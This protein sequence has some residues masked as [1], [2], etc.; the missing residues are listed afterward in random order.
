MKTIFLQTALLV[1]LWLAVAPS[2]ALAQPVP[3]KK[4]QLEALSGAYADPKPYRYGQAWGKRTFTFQKGK[5]TLVF[6][7]ALDS[8]LTMPVFQF[9]TL[10]TYRLDAPSVSVNHAWNAVFYET[11]KYLTLKTADPGL[12]QAFGLAACQL[13]PDREQD[14]SLT[15]CSLWKPISACNE[16]HDLLAMDAAGRLYFGQRPADNDMCTAAKRP[17]ALT[18]PVTRLNTPSHQ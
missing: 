17:T 1:A 5:W 3:V 10:G 2:G 14:I 9:R 7:L 6:T 18:P 11:H 8:A 4:Q 16:D 15:G 12:A 13:T